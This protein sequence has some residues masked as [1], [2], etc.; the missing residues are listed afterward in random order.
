MMKQQFPMAGTNSQKAVAVPIWIWIVGGIIVALLAL[1][2][3]YLQLTSM[4]EQTARHQAIDQFTSLNEEVRFMCQQAPG[5]RT[6]KRV[7]FGSGILA[8]FASS[9]RGEPPSRVPMQIAQ[10]Q[11]GEGS[12]ICLTFEDEHY[13]CIEQQCKV[14]MTYV[15]W[16]LEGTDM[17][18][19]GSRDNKFQFDLS[20]QR[21]QDQTVVVDATHV[22]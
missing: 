17:Y 3:A 16:P 12:Y 13:G 1:T 15:G 21:D 20:V 8:M 18:E 2:G 10:G 19:I 11:K 5:S 4:G 7:T 14:E 22:P 6:T 9:T